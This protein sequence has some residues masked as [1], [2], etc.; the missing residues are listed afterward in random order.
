MRVKNYKELLQAKDRG[1][2][3]ICGELG[4][5]S[6]DGYTFCFPNCENLYR[7]L[8]VITV[9]CSNYV[10]ESKSISTSYHYEL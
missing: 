7:I 5:G 1:R 2:C 4:N 10:A 9:A 8:M 6:Y 3:L